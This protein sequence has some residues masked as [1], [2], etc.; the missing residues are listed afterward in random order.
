MKCDIKIHIKLWKIWWHDGQCPKLGGC[1]RC[2]CHIYFIWKIK[3]KK[4]KKVIRRVFLSLFDVLWLIL[5]LFQISKSLLTMFTIL[6]HFY[7]I[8]TYYYR[9]FSTSHAAIQFWTV[10]GINLM[11]ISSDNVFVIKMSF[12]MENTKFLRLLITV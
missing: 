7:G 4:R 11:P 2:R 3:W 6:G 5:C 12:L 1:V 10:A 8:S 9:H